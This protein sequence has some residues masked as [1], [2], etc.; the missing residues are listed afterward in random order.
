MKNYYKHG[1]WVGLLL[2][3]HLV[4]LLG[5]AQPLTVSSLSPARNLRNAPVNTNVAVTFSQPISN[6]ANSKGALRVFSQQRGGAMRD[7][8]GGVTNIATGNTLRFNPT[9]NF[10][11]GETIF[12]TS[13]TAVKSDEGGNL[14]R[15]HVHRFTT[16]TGGTGRGYFSPPATNPNPAVNGSAYSVALG[17][18]DG[19]GDLDF[20]MAHLGNDNVSVRLNDGT[21]N[22]TPPAT[23][24]NPA[25]GTA[26]NSVALGDL[27]GDGDLDF[28]TTNLGGNTVSVRL[29]D[30]T[31]NFTPPATNPN[32]AVGVAP[33]SVALGDIDA[34]GDLDFVATNAD[35]NTV[36][37]RF[38]DGTGNFIPP[39]TNPNPAVGVY[40]TSVALGD[41]DG[42]GDLDFVTANRN[43]GNLAYRSGFVSV[44][45]NDG[46]GNFTPPATN[47]EP[48]VGDRPASV[49]LGDVNGDGNLD[50]VTTNAGSDHTVS[51]RL[52]DGTGNFTPPTTNPEPAISGS[53]DI[54][55]GDLD[56][57]GDLDFVTASSGNANVRLNDGTGNFTPPASNPTAAVGN[58]A[59]SV[60][61]GDLDGDGDL[62]FVVANSSGSNAS[63]RLN[64][65]VAST[66][67]G[68]T[69]TSGPVGST[70]TITGNNLTGE[71]GESQVTGVRFGE[72]SA[73]FTV[74]STSNITVTVP[75][76]AST[77]PIL[78]MVSNVQTVLDVFTVTRP[79]TNLTY[80]LI[81]L[82][83]GNINTTANSAPTV[84]DLDADGLLD[85]L[86][87]KADGTVDHYEQNTINGNAFTRVGSLMD[88]ANVINMG[89]NAVPV[90]SDLD[91]DGLFDLLLGRGN[92]LVYQYE[93]ST[94]GGSSF[95]L[96]TNNFASINT[97]S[98]SAPTMTDLDRDGLLDIL[99]G[100][101]DGTISH[102]RQEAVNS[103]S[104]RRVT[105]GF[106]SISVGANSAPV[107]VD[108]DG[109]GLLD[110]L[111]GNSQGNIYHYKQSTAGSLG[112]NQITTSFNSL[113][114]GGNAQPIVTDIDGDNNLDLL[115]G[116]TDG[117]ISRY[118]QQ[119][120]VVGPTIAG[121]TAS[122]NP[123][124]AG[125]LVTFTATIGNVTG[126]YTYT[127]TN[128]TSTTIGTT[129]S[130]SF[131]QNLVASGNGSQ[132][133][134][135]TVSN[136][137][138]LTIALTSVTVNA[139]T[140]SNPTVST[141][142]V[143]QPFSQ[144][145][146]ASGGNGTYSYSVVSSNLPA[147][148]S[149][150]SAGGLSGTPTAAGSYSALVRATDANGCVGESSTAY[151]LSVGNATLPC[152]TVVY[153]T[154][155]GA[156]LQNGS[157]WTNAFAGTSLQTAI[158][159][160]ATCGAQVWVAQGL[161]KPTTGTDPTIS[162]VLKEGVAI[163]GGFTGNETQLI[164][165]PGVNPVTGQ[166]SSSSLSGDIGT[167]GDSGPDSDNSGHV[168]RSEPGL[169][170][171]AVLDGFV[172]IKGNGRNA[173]PTPNALNSVVG[174]G[175]YTIRASPSIRN[176]FFI[177]NYGSSNGGAIY[178][179][180]SSPTITN[181]RFEANS[182][183]M[184]Y[185]SAISNRGTGTITITGCLFEKHTD[186]G[187]GVIYSSDNS[188]L[189]VSTS[190]FRQNSGSLSGVFYNGSNT[191]LELMDCLLE[192]NTAKRG[193]GAIFHQSN[194][195]VKLI[196]CQ[197]INNRGLMRDGGAIYI[198]D[199]GLEA[200]DCRFTGN[201]AVAEG[202]GISF[203]GGEQA[204]KLTNCVFE[205]NRGGGDGGGAV[206]VN[207][208]PATL[209]NTSF[210]SN[211]ANRGGAL[212]FY[213][214]NHQVINCSFVN[215]VATEQ[216][217]AI[218]DAS[219]SPQLTNTSFQGNQAPQGGAVYSEEGGSQLVN[220]VFFGNGGANTFVTDGP[221]LSASYSLF[222]PGVTAYTDEGN[223]LTT[224]L[225]PFVST[226][227]TQLRDCS[228]AI[229]TGSNAA[230]S[231]ANGPATDLAGAARQFNGG[232]IDRGAY[233]Y[234]GMPTVLTVANPGVSTATVNQQ[235]SQSFTAQGGTG[236]Y[237]FSVLSSN[238]P[239]SLSVSSAGVLSG[240]P[241]TAGSY[242]VL[243]QASDANGCGGI[244]STA[245]S[246][247]VNDATPTIT[248]FAVTPNRV[249]VG[250][251]ITF[252]ATIGNIAGN[253]S[254]SLENG[255]SSIGSPGPTTATAFSVVQ[256]ASG[257]GVQTFTLT[258]NSGGQ[259][260]TAT[261][262]LTV[263]I[264]P[265]A[266]LTNNGP[267]TCS[268]TSVT[269][270]ASGGNSFTFSTGS[271]LVV[272][273][274]GSSSTVVVS[275][276]G[277]YSVVVGNTSGCV[278]AASTTVDQD[279]T[280]ASVS[281][282]PGSA[283]LT[284][285]SP[286]VSLT[287]VGVGSVRWNTGSTS[288]ILTV[289]TAGTYSVTLT[290]GS[291]CTAVTSVEVSADQSAPS[292]SINPGSAT[293]SC[294]SP[295]VSLT[296]VGVGSVLWNTGSTS[297]ILTVSS[298]GTYSVTLTS[299]SGCT[300]VTSVEVSADQSAPSVSINP[301]SATLSCASPSVSLTAVGVGSVLW[302]TGSTSPILTVSSAGTYSVTLT[303]GSGCTAVTSVEVSA[304]QSA[305]SVSINPG[306]ATL[307]CAS[308]SVSLTAVGVGSVLW[309]TGST[310]P[311]LTVSSAGTYS[312]TLTSGSGC[313]AVTSVEVS[314]DQS[315]PSVSINPSSA[316]LTCA[317]PSV[318]LTAVGV[319]SVRWNT[320]STS[321]ILTVSTAGTYSVTLTSGSGC[322]AVTSVEVSADQSAPSVSINPGSATL[323]CA[324]PSVSLTAVGV[325]SV[326]WN[327]GST[328]PILTVSTA[329]TY[330]VTLTS[331]SGCTA[332]ASV[333]VS[334]DQSAPS[335]SINPSSATLTC[336]TPSVSLTAVGVGSVR[337]NT[338][339]TSPILTVS[340]AGTYSV[341]LTSGSG[342]TA[343][344]SVEVSADQS[345]PS[346]SINP[347]SA[348][349]SCAS[350]SV[351][352]TAVGVGSVLW[353]TGSTSPILTV[354]S[355]GT[356]SVTLTSGSGCTAVTSVEVSA[357]QSAPSVSINPSSATLSCA[358][359]SVSLTAVGV[360]SVRWN[361]GS[362][363]PILTVSTAGTYSVTL[364]SGSGC[365][366]VASV[367]VSADQSAPSVSINP[368]SATL[369]C[370]SP[371]VS[372]TAVG[373]GSVLW[374][375]GSTSPILTVSSA[376]TYSVT[377]TSGSGCTA[378][379]SVEVSQQPDQ[380]IVFTQQPASASTVTVGA[381]VTTAIAVS[382]N[383][384]GFQWFKDNLSSPVGGQTSAT[385]ML[386]NVQIAD[387][388][389][390][391]VV[392]SGACNSL[393]STAFALT[394]N[395]VQ[396]APFAIT[397]VTTLSCT[398]IL[399]NRFSVS[400]TPR[401]SGLNGQPVS[402]SVAN[403]L[404]PTTESGPYTLQ[405]YT[406]NPTLTL[407]AIQG[408]TPPE[409]SYVYNWLAA[410]RTS[411]SPNTPPGW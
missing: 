273:T 394:V 1:N 276:P 200:T 334:A 174:G 288:P 236:P 29:N 23:N 258:V 342:C 25:A 344:T 343:V 399:P 213:G 35:D 50:F 37:V 385:L 152:G 411:E 384:T 330:S 113:T 237:T 348:T 295:S 164:Q 111:I 46:T 49:A 129:S 270:T 405:L 331:G 71:P 36:S 387:A 169:T 26:A 240:T 136:G 301:G 162:F 310:S 374:N 138:P 361:T 209:I 341:T 265:V 121:F 34:D 199:A 107:V 220:S 249:C 19:D 43:R 3:L 4:S 173:A 141:A 189:I 242:S 87:G 14:A 246:L 148:L 61:L 271:G 248:G 70:L 28:V 229:N 157:S 12:V 112:F 72:L 219:T 247:A 17:D 298:A 320:G 277:V 324:S 92:G 233:E 332:V 161:Y 115:I 410:C 215:N 24:P 256:T 304:D 202:G 400:F 317:T 302:N 203:S 238:L 207:S 190:T 230:Y 133:F 286:S 269:L 185:G 366:A 250:S 159:T 356:Y 396:T 198:Q 311:I 101:A 184:A 206:F 312:V 383:P 48:A 395:P 41:L 305:P 241:T 290:S 127:L 98:N 40:P 245:Y 268:Q 244:A 77:Q 51:V 354:S 103:N 166:P 329:G 20:V 351:S 278:S 94:V 217:G 171:S 218:F 116:R 287:A 91:G 18:L 183:G 226:T 155:S 225:T 89:T 60:A 42:D 83:F 201:S 340:S 239:A 84:T 284:C 409:A 9:T 143:G 221:S 224:T 154:Q 380:T 362:T 44:R 346:V 156:G 364:T 264:S 22:F 283:T 232:V 322:T 404:L 158:N 313:T 294:A 253:Y 114:M 7:G 45:L 79:N 179:E 177:D 339:S 97:T 402:F 62:D 188:K 21:G 205:N 140:V 327:T 323:S 260:V 222:E 337:W 128:G 137:G 257:S 363:S 32:P 33:Y 47:P 172:I 117:T 122:P 180:N 391:I 160:A 66:I 125:S 309:N 369:T 67:T 254:W 289:S 274:P 53:E 146:T 181:C 150:S 325:G 335:V 261:T 318:S 59:N 336:A 109:D 204:L 52:N 90:V 74:N 195:S 280:A 178:T 175:L 30:G 210:A 326:R 319:G 333:E 144:S 119:T 197:F 345:A 401:Y 153:V 108:L 223:N 315:A 88:G 338:G 6:S 296:A 124:C 194:G 81:S 76:V 15:G 252:T 263:N 11:P 388:G 163:Y 381:N 38:N 231:S 168:V 39:A 147:S 349:L 359:P 328:S 56:G 75:K 135:L 208:G 365:T 306:S 389:S 353:N 392:V 368:S 367:E 187:S 54:A 299:G 307:S 406:D 63:V 182:A 149:L 58:G 16:A 105:S 64:R 228:P 375:T 316:T 386:T 308:P 358:S 372:L 10:K 120:L 134:T 191:E 377:L 118:E 234:Q 272:G 126:S 145:F 293:L 170:A 352:L 373:V 65:S 139:V 347:S 99:V 123:V 68:F 104:F 378:V 31:G 297:P 321:P 5:Q 106:N 93:Q 279:V 95:T 102:F 82:T 186:D 259:R 408:G 275:T 281:I 227:S 357:D 379:T 151:S 266:S 167:P 216:G 282:N 376:G 292:V 176:C 407:K 132:S 360:G 314:A 196:H 165:R 370:A 142:T 300:A 192:N 55:L 371:S 393:T 267:L 73:P 2:S 251:P 212:F 398:P 285:A 86:I 382:G 80:S 96:V 8:L 110:M 262:S 131:G 85:L 100:K 27:D 390:Y 214:T 397:A 211:T 13:T 350:P 303:S 291:G 243:V 78:F 193:G 69:P 255:G 403:E 57:D 235:F 355:A 130:T